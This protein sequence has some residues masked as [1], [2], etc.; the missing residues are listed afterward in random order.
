M[1]PGTACQRHRHMVAEGLA[2]TQMRIFTESVC[3]SIVTF[4]KSLAFPVSPS[5]ETR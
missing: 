4:S 5:C 2:K 3:D 1:S